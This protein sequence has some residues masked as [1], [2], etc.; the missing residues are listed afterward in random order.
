[1]VFHLIMK[2]WCRGGSIPWYPDDCAGVQYFFSYSLQQ[3]SMRRS[4][5]KFQKFKKKFSLTYGHPWSPVGRRRITAPPAGTGTEARAPTHLEGEAAWALEL[6]FARGQA[7]QGS[8][9]QTAPTQTLRTLS[10][11][12]LPFRN[13]M[14]KHKLEGLH[15]TCPEEG[16]APWGQCT[17]EC[18]QHQGIPPTVL[19]LLTQM[20]HLPPLPIQRTQHV[21]GK[22]TNALIF[23]HFR[24]DLCGLPEC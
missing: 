13:C 5:L 1:M 11:A 3:S 7:S 9:A 2:S 22:S 6:G 15:P 21:L 18:R 20:T 17:T 19:R 16:P 12:G 14:C 4:F 10:E 8:S 23:F 24:S